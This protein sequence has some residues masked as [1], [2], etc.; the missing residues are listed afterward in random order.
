M[1]A[2][3]HRARE[4]RG[5]RRQ[6]AVGAHEPLRNRPDA[7]QD[8]PSPILAPVS[9]HGTYSIVARDPETGDVGVAVQSHWFSVGPLCAW[10]RAGVGAVATQ[11]VVEPA[12]GPNALDRLADGTP[13]EQALG[14]LL[15]ADPLAAV[16][17]VAVIDPRGC[18][19]R[20]AGAAARAR[21]GG[22]SAGAGP[23]HVAG[24]HWSCQANMMARATVPAA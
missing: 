9:R 3:Q 13:A 16:R 14:E 11:S 23:A 17:Q 19:R 6:I 18:G 4:P 10:T 5:A 12:Y 21:P 15:A 2:A 24:E 22:A 7:V 8:L 20:R 1:A